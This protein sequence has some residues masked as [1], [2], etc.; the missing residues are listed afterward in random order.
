VAISTSKSCPHCGDDHKSKPFAVYEDGY[1]CFS[2]GKS[3]FAI[4]D[5]QRPKL[6]TSKSLKLPE[7]TQN[8]SNFSLALLKWLNSYHVTDEL[9]YKHGLAQTVDGS[10][11]TP[12]ISKESGE[13]IMYQQRWFNPRRIMTYGKKQE[14]IA[15]PNNVKYNK[16]LV[17]VEDFISAIRVGE[18]VDCFCMFGTSIP[19]DRLK[20]LV[21]IYD[22]IVIWADGDNPGQTASRKIMKSINRFIEM[23]KRYRSFDSLF[24]KNSCNI[25]TTMDPKCYTKT[26]ILTI[27]REYI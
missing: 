8:P 7:L 6:M 22:T 1:H 2:C 25:L 20:S 3:K 19:Y 26:Q 24:N 21:N 9:V 16:T 13:V 14:F 17:I 4:R 5:F 27:L 12:V 10:L 15:Y 18:L 11:L 23:H